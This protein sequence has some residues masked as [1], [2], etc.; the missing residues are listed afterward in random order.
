MLPLDLHELSNDL[1]CKN[2]N[3]TSLNLNFYF[4]VIWDILN[5][6]DNVNAMWEI[7]ETE[8]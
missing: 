6:V 8:N 1:N 3:S 4:Q 5:N 2:F 7:I